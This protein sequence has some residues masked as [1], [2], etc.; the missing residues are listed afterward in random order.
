MV[1][2]KKELYLGL[3]LSLLGVGNL[4][5]KKGY[6]F[7]FVNN[8]PYQIKFL[9]QYHG[10]C[11][12]DS[13]DVDHRSIGQL[14]SNKQCPI[15]KFTA[16][17]QDEFTFWAKERPEEK[18]TVTYTQLFGPGRFAQ[19]KIIIVAIGEPKE[20]F[21]IRHWQIVPDLEDAFYSNFDRGRFRFEEYISDFG[22]REDSA[23]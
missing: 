20:V 19:D 21:K 18:R 23:D 14:K 6:K 13:K 1:A 8:T 22:W 16:V 12:N 4:T 17:V 5:A 10:S 15:K 9:V 2:K 7:L 11:T 3:L